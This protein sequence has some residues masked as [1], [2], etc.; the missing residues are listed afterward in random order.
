MSSAVSTVFPRTDAVSL[1]RISPFRLRCCG[2][3]PTEL[4][5]PSSE[6]AQRYV[7]T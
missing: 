5:V 7:G 3:R 1:S 2:L 6:A 4:P